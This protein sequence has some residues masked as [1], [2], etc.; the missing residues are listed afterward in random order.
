MSEGIGYALGAML[1][2]A[3]ALAALASLARG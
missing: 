3:A 2:L 1:G